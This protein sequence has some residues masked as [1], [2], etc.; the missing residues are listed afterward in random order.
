MTRVPC[1]GSQASQSKAIWLAAGAGTAWRRVLRS[2]SVLFSGAVHR[3]GLGSSCSFIGR[4]AYV[5]RV[6]CF[7]SLL[8]RVLIFCR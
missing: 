2:C 4:E 5:A 6:M 7:V 3:I 1:D 8:T